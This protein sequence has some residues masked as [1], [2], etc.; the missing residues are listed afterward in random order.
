M[1][2]VDDFV[3]KAAYMA[4]IMIGALFMLLILLVL[5]LL[6]LAGGIV[7]VCAPGEIIIEGGLCRG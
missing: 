2:F 7:L 3:E 6:V 1:D 4:M 5:S